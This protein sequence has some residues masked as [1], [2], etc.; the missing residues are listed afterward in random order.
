M[1]EEEFTVRAREITGDAFEFFSFNHT[2]EVYEEALALPS[3]RDA[4]YELDEVINDLK[5][6]GIT[7]VIFDSELIRGFDYYTGIIFEVFDKHPENNRALFGGGRYDELLSLFGNEQVAAVGFGMGDVPMMETLK[8][9]DLIPDSV[10]A[11]TTD[12]AIL[13]MSE[14]A[15]P[16]AEKVAAELRASGRNVALNASLKKI[17]DQIKYAE[18]TS[19]P[20]IIIIGEDEVASG[21]YTEKRVDGAHHI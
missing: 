13:C 9:Y 12:V 2:S 1:S 19:I 7:N 17:P 14:E 3:I 6:R 21:T 11:S 10:K 5:A 18:K 16:F 4:K 8:T 15:I 20:N